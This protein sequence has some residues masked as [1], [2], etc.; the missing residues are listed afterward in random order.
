MI[1]DNLAVAAHGLLLQSS[2]CDTAEFHDYEGGY[3]NASDDALL[4][5]AKVWQHH[6]DYGC[7]EK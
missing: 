5:L 2:W 1:G 4:T 6:Q 7:W 3:A